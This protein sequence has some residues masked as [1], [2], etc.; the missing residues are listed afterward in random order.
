M[1]KNLVSD[2]AITCVA[3]SVT[4]SQR[5]GEQER[6]W[7]EKGVPGHV[8][9]AATAMGMRVQ[10]PHTLSSPASAT[11]LPPWDDHLATI[12]H[13]HHLKLWSRILEEPQTGEEGGPHVDEHAPAAMEEQLVAP[14]TPLARPAA[15]NGQQQEVVAVPPRHPSSTYAPL[16]PLSSLAAPPS[17]STPPH[18][19]SSSHDRGS[20]QSLHTRLQTPLVAPHEASFQAQQKQ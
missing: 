16:A 7:M 13:A 14:S 6:L 9:K 8:R 19:S 2:R 10:L 1:A 20:L 11:V 4:L 3:D 15:L 17:F 12:C 18:P 5:W